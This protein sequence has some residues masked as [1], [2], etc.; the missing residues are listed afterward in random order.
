MILGLSE[1]IPGVGLVPASLERMSKIST[2]RGLLSQRT[3]QVQAEL[4]T[5]SFQVQELYYDTFSSETLADRSPLRGVQNALDGSLPDVQYAAFAKKISDYLKEN[6][7]KLSADMIDRCKSLLKKLAGA[8]EIATYLTCIFYAESVQDKQLLIQELKARVKD[9]LQK[10][11]DGESLIFP[12]GYVKGSLL[13]L[14]R[15]LDQTVDMHAVLMEVHRVNESYDVVIFNTGEGINT[16]HSR[17]EDVDHGII[18]AYPAG[19]MGISLHDMDVMIDEMMAFANTDDTAMDSIKKFYGVLNRH[20]A[21]VDEMPY[22]YSPYKEQ[23]QVG[24]CSGKSIQ[25]WLHEMMQDV[26]GGDAYWT[27]RKFCTRKMIDNVTR[28]E[29]KTS[30]TFPYKHP[31]AKLEASLAISDPYKRLAI[32]ARG[33]FINRSIYLPMTKNELNEIVDR[34]KTVLDKREEKHP[35]P[36]DDYTQTT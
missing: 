23:G 18:R 1:L 5:E 24:N 9:Q 8:Q 25:V 20:C 34:A 26:D 32:G 31:I 33:F 15:M 2:V 6:E 11:S 27:F 35:S 3:L 22:G 16:Y 12:A 21:F 29:H 14:P 17:D 7:A 28:I 30:T 10:L 36:V 4:L 19:F 13:D